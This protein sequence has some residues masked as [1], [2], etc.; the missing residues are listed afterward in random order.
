MTAPEIDL[1]Q[2]L[3][4][5]LPGDA[6]GEPTISGEGDATLLLRRLN[7]LRTR[8]AKNAALAKGEIDRVRSWEQEVNGPLL[9]QAMFFES[10]LEDYMR[11]L[12]DSTEGETKSLNLPTGKLSTTALQ[13]K[14]EV[15]DTEAFVKWALEVNPDFLKFETKPVSLA[16]LK[17]ALVDNGEGEAVHKETGDLVPGLAI[18]AP[19]KPYSVSIK[20]N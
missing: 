13:P 8:I 14:W 16:E 3:E 4:G 1:D 9:R 12:R 5:D 7:N 6:N 18:K 15:E 11:F 20:T 19:E 17:K 10:I 2:Y